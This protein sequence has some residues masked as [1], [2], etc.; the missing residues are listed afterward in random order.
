MFVSRERMNFLERKIWLI[1]FLR[2]TF[3]GN[4]QYFKVCLLLLV[5]KRRIF[6]EK[7]ILTLFSVFSFSAWRRSALDPPNVRKNDQRVSLL[8]S[9]KR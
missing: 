3:R 8:T 4:I 6:G 2:V 9:M 7:I 1:Y 5:L